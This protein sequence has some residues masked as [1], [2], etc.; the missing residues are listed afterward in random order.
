MSDQ[1]MREPVKHNRQENS[2]RLEP[3][4]KVLVSLGLGSRRQMVKAIQQQRIL[5]D[6][7]IAESF[8]HPVI[9][10]VS[11]IS[12][13]NKPVQWNTRPDILIMLNKPA[14]VLCTTID[15]RG[16]RTVMDILPH[17]YR[18]SR[19]YPVGRLDKNTTGL[20]L[21]TNDGNLTYRLTHP[22]FEKEKE[23]LV[24]INGKLTTH[25]KNSIEKG[26]LLDD[27]MTFPAVVKEYKAAPTFNYSIT[28]HEGRKRQVRRMFEKLG[29]RVLTLKRIRIG[30]LLLGD[31]KEGETRELSEQEKL[32][33][34]K[35]NI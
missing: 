19:L 35:S 7:Q 11:T 26:I 5:V 2:T 31:L 3:L 22:R 12:F 33:L 18:Q 23:Y 17:K 20:L 10:Q 6:G 1:T 24:G 4:L 8:S 13:D 25:E 14:G 16:R 28:I 29:F 21:L 15:E 27:G 34:L 30:G 9:R 32:Q